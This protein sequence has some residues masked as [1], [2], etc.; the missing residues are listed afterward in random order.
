MLPSPLGRCPGRKRYPTS[1]DVERGFE[2][3]CPPA[4][5]CAICST[6]PTRHRAATSRHAQRSDA[7]A[8]QIRPAAAVAVRKNHGTCE[9]AHTLFA[10]FVLVFS[11]REFLRVVLGATEMTSFHGDFDIKSVE[12]GSGRWHARIRRASHGPFGINGV[13]VPCQAMGFA[14]PDGT[15]TVEDANSPIDR[16]GPRASRDDTPGIQLATNA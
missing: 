3:A 16:V 9:L 11:G 4:S 8:R 14:W 6:A 5:R 12:A 13:T 10:E 7:V 2:A 15:I 1:A